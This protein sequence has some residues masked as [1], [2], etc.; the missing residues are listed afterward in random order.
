MEIKVFSAN[1]RLFTYLKSDCGVLGPYYPSRGRP[2]HSMEIGLLVPPG[3]NFYRAEEVVVVSQECRTKGGDESS[4]L[5]QQLSSSTFIPMSTLNVF[6][7]NQGIAM[8]F[9]YPNLRYNDG[10]RCRVI[11]DTLRPSAMGIFPIGFQD[12]FQPPL[13]PSAIASWMSSF[14]N[15]TPQATVAKGPSSAVQIPR[16][17]MD[18]EIVKSGVGIASQNASSSRIAE[19]HASFQ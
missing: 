5:P 7:N 4:A 6:V 12:Q 18:D 14:T 10:S 3:E 16:S 17:R 8:P 2:P 11:E 1:G 19:L 15:S 13:L 9:Y